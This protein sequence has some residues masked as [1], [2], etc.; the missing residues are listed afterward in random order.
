MRVSRPAGVAVVV[1]ATMIA[2]LGCRGMPS[3]LPPIHLN[4]NMDYQEKLEAQE[5]SDFFYD[6][7]GMRLPVPGTVA[8]GELRA[9]PSVA[10]GKDAAGQLLESSPL[11]SSEATLARGADR[12]QIYC[13]PC[14]DRR[15]TGRGI[16]HQYG[17]PT[18]TFHDAQRLAYSDG[19]MFDVI[20]HGV[21]L[22]KGY[23]YQ[24]TPE[25]RWAVI[26]HVRRLQQERAANP[27]G[28]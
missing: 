10:T 9:D 6:G 18:A 25:D 20:T 19:Q 2:L 17:T 11:A 16:L 7:R 22:M 27:V 8:I 3:S 12:Y 4:P 5:A 26:A 13:Q 14:H 23:A 15:G 21:G 1:V 24:L 28:G